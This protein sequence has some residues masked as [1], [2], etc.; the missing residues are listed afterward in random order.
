MTILV[1]A[2]CV[3]KFQKLKIEAKSHSKL[4]GIRSIH[5]KAVYFQL[6]SAETPVKTFWPIYISFDTVLSVWKFET[7]KYIPSPLRGRW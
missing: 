3:K 7:V 1:W 6:Y 2:C 5:P 4:I